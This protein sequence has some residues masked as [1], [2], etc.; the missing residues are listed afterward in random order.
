MID[1]KK[2]NIIVLLLGLLCCFPLHLTAQTKSAKEIWQAYQQNKDLYTFIDGLT[3]SG[4]PKSFIRYIPEVI[5]ISVRGKGIEPEVLYEEMVETILPKCSEA[6]IFW[7]LTLCKYMKNIPQVFKVLNT[8]PKDKI[9]YYNGYISNEELRDL[10]DLAGENNDVDLAY[11]PEI[12]CV[13]VLPGGKI[14]IDKKD[15]HLTDKNDGLWN[16]ASCGNE[17]AN[18]IVTRFPVST[19]MYD[20]NGTC[21]VG[22]LRKVN[23]E[24][25]KVQDIL[26]IKELE[27]EDKVTLWLGFKLDKGANKIGENAF[28]FGTF[29]DIKKTANAYDKKAEE[30]LVAATKSLNKQV[31][32][33]YGQKAYEAMCTGKYYVGLPEGAVSGFRYYLNDHVYH[34]FAFSGFGK[35]R[36]GSYKIYKSTTGIEWNGY[37]PTIYVRNGKVFAWK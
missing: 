14:F 35:D 19:L 17:F 3:A 23:G 25:S 10:V 34:R 27:P 31:I 32:A 36:Q 22:Y 28:T 5:D 9:N 33:K 18:Q 20:P 13:V 15:Y 29:A 16:Y 4:S 2:K 21:F 7:G 26:D 12:P 8:L 1:M 11:R 24:Y 37:T 6:G 30:Q